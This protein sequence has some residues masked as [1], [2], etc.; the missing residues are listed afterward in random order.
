MFFRLLKLYGLGVTMK[1]YRT[2]IR[3]WWNKAP[4]NDRIRSLAAKMGEDRK[5]GS[6]DAVGWLYHDY[7]LPEHSLRA[8]RK[9]TDKRLG[10]LKKKVMIRGSSV[11]DIGCSSGGMTTGMALLGASRA[12]GVDYDATA[13]AI[14]QAVSEKYGI[15]NTQFT[16][17]DLMTYDVP[18]ADIILWLSH[19]MWMVQAL[20]LDAARDLLFTIPQR[21]QTSVMV[22]ESGAGDKSAPIKGTNQKSILEF[23]RGWSPFRTI[24]NCGPFPDGWSEQGEE[25]RNVYICRNSQ[26]TFTDGYQSIAKR[27]DARTL[28]K[29]YKEKFGWAKDWELEIL[30]KLEGNP[31]FP[32]ILGQGDD[33]LDLEW[34]G[35]NATKEDDLSQLNDIVKSLASAGIVHRDIRPGNLLWQE[36]NLTLIDFGW[37]WIDGRKP[38]IDA[39][40][41]LGNGFY[42]NNDWDDAKAAEKVIV[43]LQN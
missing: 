37:A 2:A 31:H 19:W 12:A 27:I 8:H 16:A 33:Y 40:E 29:T 41:Y 26:S 1:L 17:A 23:L 32:K 9:N 35:F 34:R 43:S 21:A 14:A 15:T 5:A 6:S 20:G 11:L 22:F 24:E 28:R 7:A 36:G 10:M 4:V 42:E 3:C 30:K 39:P 38:P 18:Q 25:P 13:I